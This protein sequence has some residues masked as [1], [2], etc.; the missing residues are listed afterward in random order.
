MIDFYELAELADKV[1]GLAE[2]DEDRLVE[3]IESLDEES[4]NALLQSGFLNAKQVFYYYFRENPDPLGED[5]LLLHA[6]SECVNGLKIDEYDS[7]IL[8]F[9][10]NEGIPGITILDDIEEE[11]VSF[12]GRDAYRDAL[13]YIR[14][15]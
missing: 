13:T 10:V 11:V 8:K 3:I 7:F 12:T 14:N 15:A 1:L 5:R 2:D 6:A 4:R 9:T